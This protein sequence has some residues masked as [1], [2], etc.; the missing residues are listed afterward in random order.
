MA[1]YANPQCVCACVFFSPFQYVNSPQG[2]QSGASS[3][4]VS[5]Q[6]RLIHEPGGNAAPVLLH[7]VTIKAPASGTPGGREIERE[8]ESSKGEE[9]A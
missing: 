4:R 5:L 9:V 6:E 1:S 2:Q 8:R 3:Q 7:N